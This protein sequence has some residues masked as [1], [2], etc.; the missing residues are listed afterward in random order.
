MKLDPAAHRV[1]RRFRQEV[2]RGTR[3]GRNGVRSAPVVLA[4]VGEVTCNDIARL[5][6]PHIGR[7]PAVTLVRAVAP[8]VIAWQGLDADDAVITGKVVLH[9]RASEG[10]AILSAEIVVTN[11]EMARSGNQQDEVPD[12]EARLDAI[13]RRARLMLRRLADP[14]YEVG[15][16]LAAFRWIVAI[17]KGDASVP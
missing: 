3:V 11:P 1:A 5:L 16:M 10:Q 14:K 2:L 12:A 6:E 7:L 13:A 4:D 17:A 9:A 8:N 15:E